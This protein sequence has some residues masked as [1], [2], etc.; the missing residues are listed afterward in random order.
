MTLIIAH[1]GSVEQVD[2]AKRAANGNIY[3]DTSGNASSKNKV[4]EYAVSEIGSE[5]ILF[6][7]DTYAVG[8]QRGRIEYAMISEIDKQNILRYNALKLFKDKLP[9]DGE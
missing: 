3:L 4:I 6:G 1:L 5:K 2:A 7:T 8:F 9:K